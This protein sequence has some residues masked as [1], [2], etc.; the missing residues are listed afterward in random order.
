MLKKFYFAFILLSLYLN[1]LSC[2]TVTDDNLYDVI[3]VGGGVSGMSAMSTLAKAGKVNTLLL[4]GANR[5]G[6]RILTIPFGANS[7][8]E[9][10]AQVLF[11][12]IRLKSN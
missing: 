7:H 5:L 4:E 2:I 11:L 6:G 8:L 3:V 12:H 9:M 1:C 10:G